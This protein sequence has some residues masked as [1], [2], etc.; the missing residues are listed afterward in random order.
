MLGAHLCARAPRPRLECDPRMHLLARQGT[1]HVALLPTCVACERGLHVTLLG[2]GGLTP[3]TWR[4]RRLPRG[5]SLVEAPA[6]SRTS[7]PP[8]SPHHFATRCSAEAKKPRSTTSLPASI[9]TSVPIV[10]RPPRVPPAPSLVHPSRPQP[11]PSPPRLPAV[12]VPLSVGFPSRSL[13]APVQSGS[14]LFHGPG[15]APCT[16]R[17]GRRTCLDRWLLA[18]PETTAVPG[19]H[20]RCLHT[21]GQQRRVRAPRPSPL[22]PPSRARFTPAAATRPRCPAPPARP[23]AAPP[24]TRAVHAGSRRGYRARPRR[25]PPPTWP[26][27]P[28]AA[29]PAPT[30]PACP[31]PGESASSAST[32]GTS[33]KRSSYQ[34]AAAPQQRTGGHRAPTHARLTGGTSLDVSPPWCLSSLRDEDREHRLR[35]L[36]LHHVQ[37]FRSVQHLTARP[38]LA[39]REGSQTGGATPSPARASGL[40][41]PGWVSPRGAAWPGAAPAPR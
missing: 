13:A 38:C 17:S 8:P 1:R 18:H 12:T 2:R 21:P 31:S 19:V 41:G 29:V 27:P 20:P 7:P 28:R 6:S 25:M 39:H 22:P 15:R 36:C 14:L 40:S 23:A 10:C 11:C 32:R 5:I 3:S 35:A 26:T 34:P 16:S 37:R 24:P 33:Q 9:P 4:F 30:T